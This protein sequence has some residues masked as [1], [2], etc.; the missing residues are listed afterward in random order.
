MGEIC[1]LSATCCTG[2]KEYY[3]NSHCSLKN[4]ELRRTFE[5]GARWDRGKD[6]YRLCYARRRAKLTVCGSSVRGTS[7]PMDANLVQ[8][9]DSLSCDLLLL[10]ELADRLP[11]LSHR[12][13]TTFLSQQE[14]Q[15]K[16]LEITVWDKVD[17]GTKNDFMDPCYGCSFSLSQ[18]IRYRTHP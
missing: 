17:F 16:T 7:S 8:R 13:F 4:F 18:S 10:G 9:S 12:E 6:Q 11:L 2:R 3:G 15:E 14:L 5:A 1:C